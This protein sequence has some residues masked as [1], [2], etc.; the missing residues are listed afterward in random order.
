[1]VAV[2]P[3]GLGAAFNVTVELKPLIEFNAIVAL[4]EEPR[5]KTMVVWLDDSPKSTIRTRMLVE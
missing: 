5:S 4:A 3:E 2:G 1:M